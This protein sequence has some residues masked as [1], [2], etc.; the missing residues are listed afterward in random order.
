MA[1]NLQPRTWTGKQAVLVCI[2]IFLLA[3]FCFSQPAISLSPTDAPPTSNLWISGSGFAPHAKIDIYFGT[4]DKALA[5]ADGSGSFSQIAIPAPASALPGTHW[6][7]AVE[8]SEHT[9][10]QATFLVYTSW[11]QSHRNDMMR[12]NPYENVLSV[13]NV[14]QGR[15]Q[16]TAEFFGLQMNEGSVLLQPW[17]TVSF[18]S[19]RL[20]NSHTHWAD[21]NTAN[22]V[23][24]WSVLDKWL[25][26]AHLHNVDVLYT[27]GHTPQ[28]ASS[29]PND[30]NCGGGRGLCDP[31]D[32]L[33]PDGSGPNQHW[34]DFVDALVTHNLNSPTAH[35]KYW[36]PWNEAYQPPGWHGTVAQMLRMVQDASAIIKA[37][38]PTAIVLTPSVAMGSLSRAWL[39][40]YLAAGGGQYADGIAIHGYVQRRRHTPVPEDFLGVLNQMK[41]TLAK[42]GQ[43][44][45]QL[46]DTEASWGKTSTTGFT[47]QDMQAA[48]VGRFLLLHW[49]NGV[50]R[51]YWYQWNSQDTAGTLWIPD[52]HDPR[53]PGT[54]LKPG[55]AYGQMYGWLVGA[56]LSS[57]C[58]NGGG[59]GSV[60]K[61]ELSRPGGYQA[62]AIWN[63]SM[64]C[65]QGKCGT[66]EYQVAAKYKRYRTL[67][68]KTIPI[69]KS[70]V[71]IGAKPILLEN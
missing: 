71:P 48:F 42:H 15:A 36:E 7:T 49:S 13:N 21:I 11:N 41:A 3:G 64:S 24:D 22:G 20:W 28:W 54:V 26:A 16:A 14:D 40:S 34:K 19:T 29:H 46:W 50:A 9:G 67:D 69:T 45:K 8:R 53:L 39:D 35:I 61:C 37:A 52:P 31:P 4:Q 55:I 47:D 32:D 17:P 58:S 56:S 65:K 62:E 44:G 38:D 60:W 43:Q 51:L 25:A 2:A 63:T 33:N 66:T 68:G 23:Y 57:G 1:S 12:W 30:V 6:V 59:N 18:G 70:R 10:A 27:F 5:I